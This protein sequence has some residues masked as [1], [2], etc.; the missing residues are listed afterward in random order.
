MLS[1]RIRE[2]RKEKKISQAELGEALGLTNNTISKYECATNNPDPNTL[3]NIADFF[4]V[5][6]DYLL[7]RTDENSI[8]TVKEHE[9]L[10]EEDKRLLNIFHKCSPE[11]REYIIYKVGTISYEGIPEQAATAE[12]SDNHKEGKLLA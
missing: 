7:G 5:S 11:V 12:K 4:E 1:E 3:C 2:L 8:K 6:V 10:S 9:A